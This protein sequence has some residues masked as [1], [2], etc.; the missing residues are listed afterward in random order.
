MQAKRT[1]LLANQMK[2]KERLNFDCISDAHLLHL[3][4]FLVKYSGNDREGL[5]YV[6]FCW[7]QFSAFQ[8]CSKKRGKGFGKFRETTIRLPKTRA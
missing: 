1:A 8:G 6:G 5:K 3:A 7:V 2:R 4:A